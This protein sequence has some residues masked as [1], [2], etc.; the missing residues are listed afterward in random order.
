[1]EQAHFGIR[2]ALGGRLFDLV[3][4][5]R[6]TKSLYYEDLVI[7]KV[8]SRLFKLHSNNIKITFIFGSGRMKKYIGVL[9]TGLFPM[10]GF[11]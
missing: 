9:M 11:V 5:N 6:E 3:T 7:A 1:M 2:G 10:T 4:R 8:Q